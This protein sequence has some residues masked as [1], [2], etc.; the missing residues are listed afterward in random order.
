M[1]KAE[2]K[3]VGEEREEWRKA[4]DRREKTEEE[5]EEMTRKPTGSRERAAEGSGMNRHE[6]QRENAMFLGGSCQH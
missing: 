6:R 5:K 1:M 2:R 3:R 4:R